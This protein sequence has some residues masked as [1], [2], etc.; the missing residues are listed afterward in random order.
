MD[1][2]YFLP[3]GYVIDTDNISY[4]VD[5]KHYPIISLVVFEFEKAE[6][7]PMKMEE[8]P[9]NK[10]FKYRFSNAR[11]NDFIFEII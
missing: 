1:K 9:S 7:V 10:A 3:I 11:N 2:S 6:L 4:R 8:V 5:S